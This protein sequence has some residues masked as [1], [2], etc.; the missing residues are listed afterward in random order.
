MKK[1]LSLIFFALVLNATEKPNII[2]ILADDLGYGDLGCY[3]QKVI[4]T[5]HLDKMAANGLR[6]TQHYS[7]STVCGP[8]RSCLLE[9]KHSGNTYVRGNGHL[10]MRP[11]PNDLIF[12]KALQKAGYHTAM[13]GKSGMGCNTDDASLTY[14]KD[15]ITFLASLLIHK[16]IGIFLLIYGA[17]TAKSLKLNTQ[18]TPY[19]RAITIA[20]K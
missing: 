4:Q 6:F 3:G 1:I 8:S 15:L 16:P 5:P 11:D 7:G 19:T 20:Q 10:Q 14:K 9:G 18:T 2:Y 17:M 12:P 13:I